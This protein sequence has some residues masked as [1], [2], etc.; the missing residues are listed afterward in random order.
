MALDLGRATRSL[1]SVLND[2]ALVSHTHAQRL[3]DTLERGLNISTTD[4]AGLGDQE[5]CELELG[6]P[7]VMF[8]SHQTRLRRNA[9]V[10]R[11]LRTPA[12]RAPGRRCT[13][14]ARPAVRR[15]CSP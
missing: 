1:L 12:A 14:P 10:H 7:A 2:V 4:D 3:S 8:E 6:Y 11:R 5:P 15:V 13:T 9:T